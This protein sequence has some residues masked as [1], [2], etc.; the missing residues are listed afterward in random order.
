ML[1]VLF[2]FPWI[3]LLAFLAFR[4]RLARALPA[5]LHPARAPS[6]TVIVPARN[7]GHNIERCVESLAAY[8]Y[9][10]Y[11]IVVVDDRSEDDTA[12]RARAADRGRAR[13][14]R[15]LDGSPLPDGWLGKPWACWQGA[16]AARS[17][18]LLFTDA[19][20][21][22]QPRLLARAVAG[23][24]E[25][26]ADLLT[27][28]GR[29]IMGS[30]WERLVQPQVFLTMILRFSDVDGAL[31]RGKWRNAIANGQFMLFTRRAYTALGGHEAVRGEVAEDLALAQLVAREGRV[32]S[33]RLAE[34]D[35]ATRMYRS[36]GDLIEGWS[37][38]LLMGGLKTLP[39]GLRPFM[40][41]ASLL[42][43]VAL[44]VMPPVVLA[45]SLM[46]VLGMPWLVW[47][48]VVVALSLGLWTFVTVRMGAPAAY[49]LLYPLGAAMMAYIFA[50]SWAGGRRVEWKGRKYL[51][52]D[53][54]EGA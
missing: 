37:K 54:E 42:S 47:S 3:G 34:D 39:P 14:I 6:V 49:A 8:D 46:G 4:V 40:A 52:E 17:D 51:L 26:E 20:T 33:I 27:V 44:W 24:E 12:E 5:P 25:D 35:F 9:P 11:D 28:A 31:R 16:K 23:M 43:G 48:A 22:H 1:P 18:L 50:R 2:A 19:D 15:V 30:F 29:Q 13:S 45:M 32:L 38:N 7:E 36:L 53:L 10:E 21:M 41:P